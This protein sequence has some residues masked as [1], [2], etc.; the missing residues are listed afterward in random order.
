LIVGAGGLLS[1]P[2]GAALATALDAILKRMPG[3]PADLHF[4]VFE[5]SALEWHLALLASTALL[6]ALYPMRVVARL[7]IAATLRDQVVG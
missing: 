4:F 6:A 2:V 7:P 5:R 3:I 1:L